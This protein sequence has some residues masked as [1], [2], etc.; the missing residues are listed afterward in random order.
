LWFLSLLGAQIG[1]L[2]PAVIALMLLAWRATL[3]RRDD[4]RYTGRLWLICCAVPSVA[5]FFLLSLTKPVLGSWPFPSF[6]TL[7]VL[8][9]DLLTDSWHAYWWRFAV[10][11]GIGAALLLG[12][13]TWLTHLPLPKK[14]TASI[15]EKMTAHRARAQSLDA[16]RKSL[17]AATGRPPIFVARYYMNAALDAFYLPDHPTVFCAGTQFAKRPTAYDFW[18]ATDLFDPALHGRDAVLD[19]HGPRPWE[20]AFYFSRVESTPGGVIFL[21]RGYGGVIP[22]DQRAVI[23]SKHE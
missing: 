12:F 20:G 3:Q 13:P 19:G 14:T 7:V 2:G 9:G 5:F 16:A 11:Y 8:A 21:G 10:A 4:P 1:A 22:R 15:L 6:V 17:V 18:P 23:Q